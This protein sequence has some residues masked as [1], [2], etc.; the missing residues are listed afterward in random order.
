MQIEIDG[1]TYRTL[2]KLNAKQQLHIAR[3]IMPILAGLGQGRAILGPGGEITDTTMFSA[4]APIAQVLS[5]MKDEEID[6]VLDRC[7][8][9]VQRQDPATQTWAP[10]A[11]VHGHLMFEDMDMTAM[12]RLA[13]E[14]IQENLG[15]FF[16]APLPQA[17][18]GDL[19]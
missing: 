14:V 9:V 13:V 12:L 19:S 4:M 11:T 3:R 10:V 6:Y 16:S 2:Q 17:S 15:G 18:G 7:L 5:E 8:S 1:V